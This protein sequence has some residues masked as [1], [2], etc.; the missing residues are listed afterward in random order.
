V[1]LGAHGVRANRI[2]PANIATDINA[3]FDKAA[4]TRLQPLPR[5]GR[6]ADVT[7]V[8]ATHRRRD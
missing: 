1:E 4:V 2:A 8:A 3:A 5:Q 6:P 7:E